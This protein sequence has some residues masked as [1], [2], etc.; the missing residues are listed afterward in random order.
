M[1]EECRKHRIQVPI[2]APSTC[3]SC[4]LEK[5]RGDRH[6]FA[7]EN[8]RLR[9]ELAALKAGQGEAVAFAQGNLV[10]IF[11]DST[12]S[13][14]RREADDSYTLPLYLAPPASADA[15]SVPRELLERLAAPSAWLHDLRKYQAE[16]RAILA[17][18]Q[19]VKP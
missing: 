12:V 17:Q 1:S 14:I 18:S 4:E 8:E 2:V 3:A 11:E 19:G 16:L 7:V 15:V 9:T 5:C 13:V 10:D 6:D